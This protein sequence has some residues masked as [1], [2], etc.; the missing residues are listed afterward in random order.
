MHLS[1]LLKLPR[2][3]LLWEH[4][5]PEWRWSWPHVAAWVTLHRIELGTVFNL[6]A[7]AGV[8][9]IF[10]VADLPRGLHGD[11]ALTGLD[12]LRIIE[13]GWI[14]PYVGSGLGQ[15]T[16]PLYFT[17]LI[18]RLS[19]PTSFTLHLSMALLGTATIPAAYMLLRIGFGRWV[20]LFGAVSLTF[21]FWHIFYSRSGFMLVSMP[22]LTTLAASAIILA[23]RSKT[24]WSWFIAGLVLGVGAYTYNGYSIFVAVVGFLLVFVL[25]LGRN[26][27][28]QYAK[29]G[30]VLAVGFL[31][32]ALPLIRVALIEPDLYFQRHRHT[33]VFRDPEYLEARDAG[34]EVE[35]WLG[36]AWD[37][38]TLPLSHP[39]IDFGDGMGGR[40]AM[41][42]V[43]GTLAYLGLSIAVAKWRSPPHLLMALAFVFGLGIQLLSIDNVGE[44]RRPLVV[45][46]F[47]YGLAG[48]AAITLGRW[49]ARLVGGARGRAVA[50]AGVAL[51]LVVAAPL[52]AWTYFARIVN[53]DQMHFVYTYDLVDALDLVHEIDQPGTIYFYSDRWSFDYE[54]RRFLYPDSDGVDRS[55]RFGEFSLE[56]LDDGPVTYVLY[57]PYT[58]EVDTILDLYPEG[59]LVELGEADGGTQISIYHLP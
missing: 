8:L 55:H 14:G 27:L 13:E 23:L 41:D 10:R 38:A 42:P 9:R 34:T 1:G 44:Y 29:G 12:A 32:A 22:L 6:T 24:R 54:T 26:N 33:A 56:R 57:P 16:G 20:A 17:S 18:F 36:R 15:P 31:I 39:D 4:P 53:E 59:Q 3:G 11:E 19:E 5:A 40:G 21:S 49:T 28:E 43:L 52:N 35:F 47:V 46:P 58:E 50:C 48:V 25:I 51:I 45:V 7:V 37:A 2:P 30:A